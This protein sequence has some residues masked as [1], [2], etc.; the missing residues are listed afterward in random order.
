MEFVT[1]TSRVA[2]LTGGNEELQ[3]DATYG[4]LLDE[5]SHVASNTMIALRRARLTANL[6]GKSD[7]QIKRAP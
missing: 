6:T 5:E 4:V 7:A 3:T 1:F 2:K